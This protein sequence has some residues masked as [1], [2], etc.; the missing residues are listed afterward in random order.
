[1]T[2]W[3]VE[4]DQ[5]EFEPNLLDVTVVDT[6][7]PFGN[8]AIARIEDIN[9]NRFDEYPRG[10]RVDFY[11]TDEDDVE[12]TLNVED[13]ETHTIESADTESYQLVRLAGTI[14]GE[15]TLQL[16]GDGFTQRFTGYVVERREADSDGADILEV[17]AYSFDQFLRRN[18]VDEDLTGQ[19]I[20]EALQTII[21]DYTPVFWDATNVTV[22]DNQTLT[23]SYNGEKVEDVLNSLSDKSVNEEFGVNESVEFFWEPP[24]SQPAPRDIDN[25]QWFD[26][27]IPELGAE[28]IN[29]VEVFYNG[30][31]DSVIVDDG[32]D[33][34]EL[35]NSLG[36]SGPGTQKEEITREEITDIS[37]ARAVGEKFLDSRNNTLSGTVTTFGLNDAAPGDV[38][39]IKIDERGIDG[40][41]RIAEHEMRWGEDANIFTIVEKRGEQDDILVRLSSTVDR[42]ERREANRNRTQNR[43]TNTSMAGLISITGDVDGTSVDN[44]R[45][46]NYARTQVRDGWAGEGN[47]DISHI[48]IGTDGSGLGRTNDS[49]NNEV[50]RT[51]VT[52]TLDGSFGV[53]YSGTFTQT[54]V[55][56]VGLFDSADNLIARA[57][58]SSTDIDGTVSLTVTVSNDASVDSGVVTET[59]QEAIRDVIADNSPTLPMEYAY[60]TSD[61]TLSETDTALGNQVVA[62][63]ID[64]LV[65]QSADTTDNW[66][67][68]IGSIN[69]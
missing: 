50:A 29:E 10:T 55:S 27:D 31:D 13:G 62:V 18:V 64:Q 47:L 11:Y 43:V 35:E 65:L 61:T 38:I 51:T 30:G 22:G 45:F 68:I 9:G 57:V 40:D 33:K 3:R 54:G 23:Q 58:L 69:V 24:E 20:L 60:G 48:A 16:A 63:S 1:M 4:I 46:V 12:A 7:N 67:N 25:T 49:L 2:E 41:F 37:D 34:T 8:H 26:Y 66:D 6:F 52:E 14:D 19:T 56:E 53:S 28:K 44:S 39:N 42:V 32:G 36:L 15:G 59:G 17:E 21:E 5:E